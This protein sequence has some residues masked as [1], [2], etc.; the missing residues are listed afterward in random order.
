NDLLASKSVH[1]IITNTNVT[2]TRE[3]IVIPETGRFDVPI[4][5]VKRPAT[6]TNN[7]DNKRDMIAPIIAI[8]MLPEIKNAS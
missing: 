1:P 4:V 6:M 5:P 8:T 2:I 7:K 3:A